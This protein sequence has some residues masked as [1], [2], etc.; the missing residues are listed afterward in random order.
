MQKVR[1][2]VVE[3]T[4]TSCYV[5]WKT[6]WAKLFTFGQKNPKIALC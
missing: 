3:T 6:D 1:F 4:D 5:Q 2:A